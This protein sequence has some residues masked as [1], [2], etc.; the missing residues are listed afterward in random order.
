MLPHAVYGDRAWPDALT[1]A[2]AKGEPRE[3]AG[4][5]VEGRLFLVAAILGS[6]ALWA[7]AREA[8]RRRKLRL[9]MLRAQRAFSRAFTGRLRYGLD[10]GARGKAE[11]MIFMCPLASK[12]MR[13]DEPALEATGVAP[14]GPGDALRLGLHAAL[15]DWRQDPAVE[16]QRCRQA[17]VW[18]SGRIPAVLDGEPAR[19]GHAV[20]VRFRPTVARVLAPPK[21]AD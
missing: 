15:G 3:V 7:P 9:A 19:L 11:A 17:R 16:V 1:D 10:S 20:E 14:T 18:S 12:A 2:L 13:D 4:G 21:D 6:P 5:E 8:A